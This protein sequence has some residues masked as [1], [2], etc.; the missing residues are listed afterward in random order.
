MIN[1]KKHPLRYFIVIGVSVQISNSV[2]Y[3]TIINKNTRIFFMILL[4]SLLCPISGLLF[5]EA[6]S[7]MSMINGKALSVLW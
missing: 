7:V 3:Y 4:F 6:D 1:T 2:L 5:R